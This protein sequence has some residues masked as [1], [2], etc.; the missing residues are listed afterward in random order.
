M[1]ELPSIGQILESREKGRRTEYDE[2]VK[3]GGTSKGYW[4]SETTRLVSLGLHI[5]RI[6][7]RPNAAHHVVAKLFHVRDG[8]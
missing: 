1:A 7:C 4:L 5:Q 3:A 2:R 6:F 8:R